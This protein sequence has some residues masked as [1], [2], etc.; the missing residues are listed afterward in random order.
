MPQTQTKE[1]AAPTVGK[2]AKAKTLKE[3]K[4]IAE[5]E[6]PALSKAAQDV[7]WGRVKTTITIPGPAGGTIRLQKGKVV[8]SQGYNFDTLK[9]GGVDLEECDPPAWWL[10][11]QKGGGSLARQ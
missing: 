5:A 10:T 4:E 6:E 9:N 1:S 7:K 3:A 8:S 11:L 2:S